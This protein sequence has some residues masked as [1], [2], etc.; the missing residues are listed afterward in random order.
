NVSYDQDRYAATLGYLGSY[1]ETP[2]GQTATSAQNVSYVDIETKGYKVHVDGFNVSYT[3]PGPLLATHTL[4]EYVDE[5]IEGR[6]SAIAAQTAAES[7]RDARPTQASYDAM[8]AER[9]ARLTM[10]EVRDARI[11]STM[12]EVS[13][14]KAEITM[15]LEETTDINDWSDATTTEKTIEVDAPGSARFYRFKVAE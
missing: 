13:Q 3:V 9:D 10:D 7:E 1:G 12:I 8:V 6:S 2:E 4:E 5:L 15:T 14:G 11:G